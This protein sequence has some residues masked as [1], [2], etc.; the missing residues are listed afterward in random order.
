MA[1]R[2]PIQAVD[3]DVDYCTRNYADGMCGASLVARSSRT[4]RVL[5]S[6]DITNA[7]WTKVQATVAASAVQAPSYKNTADRVVENSATA[8][9]RIESAYV[10]LGVL[11]T[12]SVFVKS[13]GRTQAFLQILG[14]SGAPSVVSSTLIVDLTDGSIVSGTAREVID[15]GDGWWRISVDANTLSGDYSLRVGPA[16]AGATSYLG[17][18]TS[19]ILA[20]GAQVESTATVVPLPL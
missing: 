4:N 14:N 2:E 20:W 5:W 12:A 18:G 11:V 6:E 17:D 15:I 8:V 19:G 1:N 10:T 3:I 16:L 9:H 7:S 13:S